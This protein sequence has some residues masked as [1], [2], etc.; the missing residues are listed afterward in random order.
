MAY[1]YPREGALNY[2]P[3]RYGDSKL[4]FRGPKAD[5]GERYVAFLGG[6]E[7]YGKYVETPY[8]DLVGEEVGCATLNLGCVNAGLDAY[9][10]DE[11]VMDLCAASDVTVLQITGA[12]NMSNR[13]YAVHPRRNDRFLR[14]SPL[15]QTIYSE[16][17]FTDFNFTRHLLRTL[18]AVSVKKFAMVRQELK[19]AWVARMRTM[20]QRIEGDVVLFWLAD[21]SPDDVVACNAIGGDPL[22]V[23]REMLEEIRPLVSDVVEIVGTPEDIAQGYTKM[24][25]PD[26]DAPAAREM[27]GPVV[28]EK[29]ASSL[30]RFLKAKI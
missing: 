10:N 20:V 12:Q 19:D 26:L 16:V 11:T 25:Y 4:L 13:F 15:L 18:E 7:T 2:F 21:H 6:T 22:F 28:H 23:D 5:L 9:L 14:A 17:D 24:V 30:A 3:V 8:P 27:L 1:E 29:A